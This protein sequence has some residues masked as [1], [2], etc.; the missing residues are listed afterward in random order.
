MDPEALVLEEESGTVYSFGD[1]GTIGQPGVRMELQLTPVQEMH[2][3]LQTAKLKAP[4]IP[5]G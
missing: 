5:N 1:N 3:S 2:Y 4:T